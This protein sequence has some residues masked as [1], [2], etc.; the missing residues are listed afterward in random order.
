MSQR[1]VFLTPLIVALG[2]GLVLYTAIGKDP[3]KLETARLNDPLP[4]FSLESLSDNS[5]RYD[6]S[7]LRGELR[8]LNVWATWCPACRAEHPYLN[9][10]AS[11][12]FKIVGLNYK[13]ERGAALKW[14]DQLGNPYEFNIYD[15]DGK[16]GFDLGVYGAPETYVID[17]SG[18][19]R[20]RH[21][22]ELNDRV[23]ESSL[24]PIIAQIR[25]ESK[26]GVK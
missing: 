5:K 6:E 20:H 9:K 15:P 22:G 19:V 3:T 23:W 21:V 18:T 25:S 1:W 12:G 7:A 17:A 24:A 16:L 8:L 2:L 4:R 10:L 11:N 13:D 14:L 26:S